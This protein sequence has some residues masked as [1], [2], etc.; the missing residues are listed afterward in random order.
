MAK[1]EHIAVTYCAGKSRRMACPQIGRAYPT[2]RY[3]ID[4]W[5]SRSGGVESS[6]EQA[7]ILLSC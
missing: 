2:L 3:L 5:A 6:S 7:V 4:L 1:M